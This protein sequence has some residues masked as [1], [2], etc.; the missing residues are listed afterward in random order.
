[1][2]KMNDRSSTLQELKVQLKN[3]NLGR[4]YVFHGEEVFHL[5]YYLTQIQKKLLD[6]LTESFNYHHFNQETF[7]TQS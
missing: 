1:M 4:L 6:P 7:Q 5:M 2:A 3:Q